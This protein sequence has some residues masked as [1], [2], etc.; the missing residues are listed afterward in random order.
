MYLLLDNSNIEEIKLYLWLDNKWVQHVYQSKEYNLVMAIDKC[1]QEK[2]QVLKDLE[3]IVVLVGKGSFTSTRI[4]VTVANTLSYALGIP[5]VATNSVEE[6]GLVEKVKNAKKGI[7]V[8][9]VY[10]GE[11]NIGKKRI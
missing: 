2:K 9:A 11:P 8:S 4:A 7:L 3:G 6:I 10:S 5:V 1:L